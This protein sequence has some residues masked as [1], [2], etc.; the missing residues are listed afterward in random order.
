MC[1]GRPRVRAYGR[2]SDGPGGSLHLWQAA[3]QKTLPVKKKLPVKKICPSKTAVPFLLEVPDSML[4]DA[5]VFIFKNPHIS[6]FSPQSA[7]FGSKVRKLKQYRFSDKTA[8]ITNLSAKQHKKMFS[9]SYTFLH[10]CHVEKFD[11]TPLHMWR[12]FRFLHIC[13]I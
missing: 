9:T 10:I 1:G 7:I 12:S 3:R 11:S 4:L 6:L 5:V 2:G 8:W 13:H